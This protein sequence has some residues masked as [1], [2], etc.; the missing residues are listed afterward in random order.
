MGDVSG[1]SHTRQDSPVQ[2]STGQPGRMHQQ[3]LRTDA[4]SRKH[5]MQR[6]RTQVSLEA[7]WDVDLDVH[8]DES[9]ILFLFSFFFLC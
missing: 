8:C 3:W 6:D 2:H 9:E 4:V 7:I 5:G 1:R